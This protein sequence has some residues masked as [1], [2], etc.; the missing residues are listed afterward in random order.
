[1]IGIWRGCIVAIVMWIVI[2]VCIKACHSYEEQNVV[3][4]GDTMLVTDKVW[5]Y[6]MWYV[7]FPPYITSTVVYRSDDEKHLHTIVIQ[8]IPVGFW[9]IVDSEEADTVIMI[10]R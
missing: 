10:T 7:P 8:A 1:M 3:F 4:P 5:G 6:A 9:H 2:F